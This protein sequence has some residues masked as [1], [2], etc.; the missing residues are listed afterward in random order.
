MTDIHADAETIYGQALERLGEIRDTWYAEGQPLL[1][2]GSKGQ[3]VEHPLVKMLR[4][5]EAHVTRLGLALAPAGRPGRPPLAVVSPF[6]S[7]A[8]SAKL[9]LAQKRK[10]RA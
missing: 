6:L 10:P 9:K 7:P 2:V 5:Q 1:G 8:P 4:V 3:H